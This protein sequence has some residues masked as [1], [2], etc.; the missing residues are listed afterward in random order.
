[1]IFSEYNP[2]Y[3]EISGGALLKLEALLESYFSDDKDDDDFLS[4]YRSGV[5]ASAKLDPVILQKIWKYLKDAGLPMQHIQN[6]HVTIIYSKSRPIKK[7][8][9]MNITGV[10]EPIGFGIFGKGSQKEPYVLVLRFKSK[11]LDAAHNTLKKE[12]RLK[13]T[14]PVFEPHLT[15]VLDINRL[16]PGLRKLSQKQKDNILGVFD[17]MLP[18][19]PKSIRILNSRIEPR[20]TKR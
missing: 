16:F 3:K 13:P 18:D 10:V 9:P 19:L 17:K 8:Q 6:A 20:I 5:Y 4:E 7:P 1:L 14:Y 2:Q 15:L 11:A 12:Y